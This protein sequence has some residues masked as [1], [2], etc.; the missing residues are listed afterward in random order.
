MAHRSR[1]A[2]MFWN[3]AGQQAAGVQCAVAYLAAESVCCRRFPA[4]HHHL[5]LVLGAGPCTAKQAV[6]AT[7]AS[8]SIARTLR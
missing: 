4:A 5:M 2:M 8:A 1:G 6:A 3:H 7:T